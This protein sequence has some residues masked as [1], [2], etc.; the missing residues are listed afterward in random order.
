MKQSIVILVLCGA[1]AACSSPA[2]QPAPAPPPAAATGIAEVTGTAPA[3][4]IVSLQ[5]AAGD[6]PMPS[7]PA[8]MDQYAK[9]FVPGVLYVRVGQP[10]EFRNTEDMGHN[11]SVNRRGTGASVFNVETDPQQKHVHTFDRVGQYDVMCSV[12]PGMQATVIA[13]NS[14]MA[15]V[16]DDAGNFVIANV[17]AGAYK[18]SVTFE[19]RTID[20]AVDVTGP[21][22]QVRVLP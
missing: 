3:G 16:A 9:Q 21:R 1:A 2:S 22:T 18:L 12:H 11:V 4:A 14:P 17:P 10:V 6:I 8:V 19:G 20:Q 5:P 15:T 13:T 7:G